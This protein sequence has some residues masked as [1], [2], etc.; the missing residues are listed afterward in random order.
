MPPL[1]FYRQSI[2]IV[3]T[4]L[5]SIFIGSSS[6]QIQL[7]ID[8]KVASPRGGGGQGVYSSSDKWTPGY[9]VKIKFLD[10]SELLRGKV[11]QYAPEWM[12]FANIRMQF[13][14]SG[15]ADVKI[16]FSKPGS[17][18]YIGTTCTKFQQN[19]STM[20]FGWFNA[21]TQEYEFRRTILHEF[22]HALGLLHEHQSPSSQIPWNYEK[23]YAHYMQSQGWTKEMVDQ[24][25]F[26]RYSVTQSNNKYDPKSIM[27]Y[28]IP[29][30]FTTNGYSVGW[31]YDLSEEDKRIIAQMYPFNNTTPTTTTGSTGALGVQLTKI[32]VE[33]NLTKD[34]KL[35]M[36]IFQ[37]FQISNAQNRKCLISAH[38]YNTATGQA[39]P[40]KNGV[41]STTDKTVSTYGGFT[42]GYPNT[43]FNRLELFLPYDELH[44]GYGEHKLRMSVS[45]WDDQGKELSRGGDYFFDYH[46]GAIVEKIWT[47]T[48][49]ET[50]GIR[51]Y[52]RFTMKYGRNATF[53]VCAYFHDGA[54]TALKDYNNQY[55]S[56]DGKVALCFDISPGYDVAT[57]NWSAQMNDFNIFL[58]YSELHL[59][60]G[61]HNLKYYLIIWDG[62]N[63]QVK[64]GE[65]VDFVVDLN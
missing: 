4:T 47:E 11:R 28:P 41:Y 55:N 50:N 2:R 23:V 7:C 22:G 35:G 16:S 65:W 31:N 62:N 20:N 49:F 33:H 39:L 45:I 56:V 18:S 6:A 57:Y 24:Q 36:K 30:E 42:P 58:P 51:V 48:R 25:V 17:W 43:S 26:S 14:E 64:I 61:R 37:T 32:E 10:G 44:L 59:P 9:V 29:A 21:Q 53:K 12:R 15:S 46:N 3:A 63:R 60:R 38:F 34:G 40:D 54:G 27:H 52:P 1:K 13:I 19:E 8:P 5:L